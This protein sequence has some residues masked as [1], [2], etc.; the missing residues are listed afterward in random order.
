[1]PSGREKLTHYETNIFCLAPLGIYDNF[2]PRRV[3]VL[4]VSTLDTPQ[5]CANLQKSFTKAKHGSAAV[6]DTL[7]AW[8]DCARIVWLGDCISRARSCTI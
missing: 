8:A 3:E 7:P 2:T 5:T 6:M 1:M 4:N